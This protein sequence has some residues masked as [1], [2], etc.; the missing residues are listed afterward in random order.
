MG[1]RRRYS[2]TPWHERETTAAGQ[3]YVTECGPCGKRS[4][5]TR[6][7]ARKAIRDMC[8]QSMREYRYVHG[9]VWHVGHLPTSVRRGVRTRDEEIEIRSKY[10][11]PSTTKGLYS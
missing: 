5:R 8:G 1:F 3:A 4:Y 2:T 6:R 11:K 9:D 10:R 7:N